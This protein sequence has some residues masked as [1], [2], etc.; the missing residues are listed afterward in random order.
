[1]MT[2]TMT[3]REEI[4][5]IYIG[6]E[7]RKERGEELTLQLTYFIFLFSL[8]LSLSLSPFI[9]THKDNLC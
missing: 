5:E 2:T 4:W 3:R 6:K 9:Y 1:M 8:S 7:E